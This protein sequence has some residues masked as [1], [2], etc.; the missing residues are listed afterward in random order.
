MREKEKDNS[1]SIFIVTG[2]QKLKQMLSSLEKEKPNLEEAL[3]YS[4]EKS[5]LSLKCTYECH[6]DA[7]PCGQEISLS[8]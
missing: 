8:L 3:R 7:P 5:P 2:V 6:P 4:A 1:H